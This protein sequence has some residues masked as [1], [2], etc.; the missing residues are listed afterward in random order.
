M[1][2]LCLLSGSSSNARSNSPLQTLHLRFRTPFKRSAVI[3][4][5]KGGERS[6]IWVDAA[7]RGEVGAAVI[8]AIHFIQQQED[9]AP[10]GIRALVKRPPSFSFPFH[11][12][13]AT[14]PS[15]PPTNERLGFSTSA[16]ICSQQQMPIFACPLTA[17]SS[18]NTGVV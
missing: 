15:L 14:P 3:P 1:I 5:P 9:D 8:T 16:H 12:P 17:N 2:D 13:Q 18:K 7:S 6:C 4:P 10:S 11:L